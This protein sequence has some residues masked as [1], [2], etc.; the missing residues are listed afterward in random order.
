MSENKL[1][2]QQPQTFSFLNLE[3]FETIQRVSK[4]FANSELVPE[5]YKI[6]SKNTAEKAIS[7]CMVAVEMAQIVGASPLMV[8]QNMI[9]IH[10][11]PSWSSKFLISTVNTSGRFET[12]QYNMTKTGKVGKVSYIEY[13]WSGGRKQAVKKEFDG[14]KLDNIQ[15]IAYTTAKGSDDVLESTP[16]DLVMAIK[17]G[18]YTK[19]GSKWQTMAK[20]MLMYRSASFW[21]NAYAPELSM[22]M[23]TEEEVRDI[24]DVDYE[25]IEPLN[26]VDKV[27]KEIS[28]NANQQ[29]MSMD[30]KE[31]EKLKEE[32][33]EPVID[34]N[35]PG[36]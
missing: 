36:F 18:W 26:T 32:K 25:E 33:K 16:I 17:E 15:C 6:S 1:A 29:V 8:M 5:M 19:A 7:N 10:G 30:D 21:T 2:V 23:K 4:M 12:L 3:Q 13:E 9:I 27:G 14:T 34:P 11:K 28:K 22:G 35:T 20:Q 31:S 24:I